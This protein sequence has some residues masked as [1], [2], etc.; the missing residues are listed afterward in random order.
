[1]WRFSCWRDWWGD[2][3]LFII[4]R[5]RSAEIPCGDPCKPPR[6]TVVAPAP[7]PRDKCLARMDTKGGTKCPELAGTT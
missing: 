3:F 2:E 5:F 7:L 6:T 1:M 4:S